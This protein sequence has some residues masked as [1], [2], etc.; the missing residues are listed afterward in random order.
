MKIAAKTLSCSTTGSALIELALTLPIFLF[1]LVGITDF[2]RYVYSAIEV[3]DAAHAA[4]Q[5]GAQNHVTASD[6]AGMVLAAANDAPDVSGMTTTPTHFCACSNATSTTVS[7]T[8]SCT[9][10][11]RMIEFVQVNTSATIPPIA[12]YPGLSESALTVQGQAI[13]RTEQ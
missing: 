2:G 6:N 4:A 3:C 10:G 7:C 12:K 1:F 11:N 13:M 8:A 9:T 5:Y